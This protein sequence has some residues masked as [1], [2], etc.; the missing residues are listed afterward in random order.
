M[1]AFADLLHQAADLIEQIMVIFGS[2]VIS[3]KHHS[4]MYKD[5]CASRCRLSVTEVF[6]FLFTVSIVITVFQVTN[7]SD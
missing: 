6:F 3:L 7:C 5:V 1:K 2:K 4:E